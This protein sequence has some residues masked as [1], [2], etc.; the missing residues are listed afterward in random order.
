MSFG[1]SHEWRRS[2]ISSVVSVQQRLWGIRQLQSLCSFLFPI[3]QQAFIVPQFQGIFLVEINLNSSG[4]HNSFRSCSTICWWRQ[5]GEQ[6]TH[7]GGKAHWPRGRAGGLT[8]GKSFNFARK[9]KK[10]SIGCQPWVRG[11]HL[12]WVPE[13]M[14]SSP[15][16]E[17]EVLFEIDAF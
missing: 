13:L 1:D 3:C 2:T 12:A 17:T 6:D 8:R 16:R 15:A 4:W 11:V 14:P 10:I 7:G 9:A 5:A